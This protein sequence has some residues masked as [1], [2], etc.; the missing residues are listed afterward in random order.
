MANFREFSTPAEFAAFDEPGF[1]RMATS[2]VLSR[3]GSGTRLLT[4]TRVQPTDP[5][6]GR[7]FARYWLVIRG[8]S[9]LIRR[10]VLRA[11][12]PCGAFG[13]GLTPRARERAGAGSFACRVMDR[14]L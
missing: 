9:G 3:V 8:P 10:D 14:H 13:L 6:S 4:E 5:A 11:I 2:F 7:A 1:E 12:A